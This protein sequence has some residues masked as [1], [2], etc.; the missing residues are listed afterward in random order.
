M[1]SQ[2]RSLS[3]LVFL[4][5]VLLASGPGNAGAMDEPW[6]AQG[7][8][9]WHP[10]QG[11]RTIGAIGTQLYFSPPDPVIIHAPDDIIPIIDPIDS[12]GDGISDDKDRCPGTPL[13]TIV[14][15][16]GCDPDPDGDGV[17]RE[18]DRCPNTPAG[19]V[20][21]LDGCWI[22]GK[23]LFRFDRTDIQKQFKAELKKVS[24]ALGKYPA[25]QVEMVGHTDSIGSQEYN[26]KLSVR[27]AHSVKKSL[28]S[29]GI[30]SERMS[31]KGLGEDRPLNDNKT[32]QERAANRRVEILSKE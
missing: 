11:T 3:M 6:K 17:R 27:R 19:V 26:Q 9:Q 16:S 8:W 24:A 14:D 28:L 30:S 1:G 12:D 2:K 21:N 10:H 29:L 5:G 23:I 7:W 32:A 15:A 4:T 31:E 25:M 13:G 20:V 18:D 22:I